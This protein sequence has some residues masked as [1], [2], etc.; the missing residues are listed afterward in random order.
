[1]YEFLAN[2]LWHG[3][4]HQ[5][6]SR[7]LEH[8]PEAVTR[9]PGLWLQPLTC[10]PFPASHVSLLAGSGRGPADGL[11]S[12][13]GC[14]WS[15]LLFQGAIAQRPA[16]ASAQL[17][18]SKFSHPASWVSLTWLTCGK[19]A[20]VFALMG[21][22]RWRKQSSRC[23]YLWHVSQIHYAIRYF[24]LLRYFGPVAQRFKIRANVELPC[25]PRVWHPVL[26]KHW[27][28]T[29]FFLCPNTSRK[30]SGSLS[31]VLPECTFPNGQ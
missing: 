19:S 18:A 24:V 9:V 5:T 15:C 13:W 22:G 8:T 6:A 14:H 29:C 17:G 27:A 2:D 12:Y 7:W 10:V 16:R 3:L 26:G 30:A 20:D 28:G 4:L 23:L 21:W 11:S 1:M 31:Q 25:C